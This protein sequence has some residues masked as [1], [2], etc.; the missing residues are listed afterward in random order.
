MDNAHSE[1]ELKLHCADLMEVQHRLQRLRA[2]Q[3]AQRVLEINFRY[4]NAGLRLAADGIILR[5]RQDSRARL[6]LKMPGETAPGQDSILQRF[7]A[8]VEVSDFD[9]AA[10]ILER[11]GYHVQLRYEK[12]RST[13]ALGGAEVVLDELP[14][15]NFV[16]IEGD[17][18]QIERVVKSLALEQ[19]PRLPLS[20]AGLFSVIQAH[21][22]LPLHDLTFAAFANIS[23]PPNFFADLAADA[24]DG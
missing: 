17:S 23:L 22:G 10:L 9:T 18:Q 20:Y 6:T 21:L 8:E 13:W 1:T 14:C 5:L 24:G 11:L 12:Y 19:A 16:E 7:E 3:I 2:R 4:E 15:G